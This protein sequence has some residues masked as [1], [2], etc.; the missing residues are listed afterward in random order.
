MRARFRPRRR[1]PVAPGILLRRLGRN[2]KYDQI[3]PVVSMNTPS[4][5]STTWTFVCWKAAAYD[6]VLVEQQLPPQ[7]RHRREDEDPA[8]PAPALDR[9]AV[10]EPQ[11]DHRHEQALETADDDHRQDGLAER[12][13]RRTIRPPASRTG[14]SRSQARTLTTSNPNAGT[15]TSV[16]SSRFARATG[17]T[18]TAEAMN[19]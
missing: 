15:R 10:E 13:E 4:V 1:T 11:R 7:E 6:G 19:P 5:N 2:R 12:R 17:A 16:A 3:P 18:I 8:R 14:P 9:R